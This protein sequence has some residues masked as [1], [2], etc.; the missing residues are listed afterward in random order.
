MGSSFVKIF[1]Y[2]LVDFK[3]YFMSLTIAF[4]D[5]RDLYT[6][7][8]SNSWLY[9]QRKIIWGITVVPVP[10]IFQAT[11][12]VILIASVPLLLLSCPILMYP[13]QQGRRQ[14]Q[15]V[16]YTVFI[17]SMLPP[18][19]VPFIWHWHM[20]SVDAT[21]LIPVTGLRIKLV[22][23]RITVTIPVGEFLKELNFHVWIKTAHKQCCHHWKEILTILQSSHR[24]SLL[25]QD[26][27]APANSLPWKGIIYIHAWIYL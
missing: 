14:D 7:I 3:S 11:I 12:S 13:W 16:A 4:Y 24:W 26:C 19:L 27:Q 17:Y 21:D 5:S 23:V 2:E 9:Q 18:N 6:R 22:W 8:I 20:P 10:K 25:C 1:N 15:G